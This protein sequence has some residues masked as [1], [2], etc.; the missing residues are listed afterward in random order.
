[1]ITMTELNINRDRGMVPDMPLIIPMVPTP[2]CTLIQIKIDSTDLR[3]LFGL[4]V[5]IAHDGKST[6]RIFELMD[7]VMRAGVANLALWDVKRKHFI[8]IVYACEKFIA[9]VYPW[10]EDLT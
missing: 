7:N 2:E 10:Y 9:H 3:G 5:V 6:K 4:D 1:M 8:S